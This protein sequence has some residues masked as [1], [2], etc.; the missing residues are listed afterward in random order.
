MAD[1][2]GYKCCMSAKAELLIGLLSWLLTV[3][4]IAAIIGETFH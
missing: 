1:F 2:S 3:G 4:L